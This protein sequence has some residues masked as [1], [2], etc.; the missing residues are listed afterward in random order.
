ML[1]IIVDIETISIEHEGIVEW[2]E[3]N[4]QVMANAVYEAL[5]RVAAGETKTITLI[6]LCV[7]S[8]PQFAI[9]LD[10]ADADEPARLNEGF[11]V[12]REDW[13]HAARVRDIREYIKNK[14]N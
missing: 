6:E 7:E 13:F 3:S 9:E 14:Q 5:E 1:P 4:P 8:I 2:V 11:W 12:S 10:P